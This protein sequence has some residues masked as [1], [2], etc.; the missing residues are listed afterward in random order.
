ME[1]A[2][3]VTET[4]RAVHEISEAWRRFTSKKAACGDMW[5]ITWRGCSGTAGSSAR[6]CGHQG[7]NVT[8]TCC[9]KTSQCASQMLLFEALYSLWTRGLALGGGQAFT[10]YNGSEDDCSCKDV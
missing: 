10:G 1:E 2:V 8:E 6:S 5:S 9:P 4:C 7:I 3:V